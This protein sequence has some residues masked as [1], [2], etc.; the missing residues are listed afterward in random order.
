MSLESAHAPPDT[1]FRLTVVC[2]CAQWCGTCREYEAVFAQLRAEFTQVKFVWVDVEDE[3]ELVD[4]VEVEDFPTLLMARG[5][6]P[7]FF[8]SVMPHLETLRRLIQNQ[9]EAEQPPGT[10]SADVVALTVRLQAR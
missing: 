9:L 2:L 7:L 1:R 6:Q 5:A 8:G 4:P 3:S 10:Q